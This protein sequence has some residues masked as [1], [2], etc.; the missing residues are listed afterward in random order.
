LPPPAARSLGARLRTWLTRLVFLA[1]GIVATLVVGA[2][3]DA[4]R[5]HPELKPWHRLVPSAESTAADLTDTTTLAEYQRREDAVFDQVHRQI[6]QALADD[7]RT[8]ANRYNPQGIASPSRL[9]RDYNRTFELEPPTL[10]G[11]ALLVHGLSDSPYSMRALAER[12]AGAGYYTLALRMQGHGSVP[13]GLT[14]AT[15][16]DWS[17]A[18]RLGA[19]HV[20]ERIGAGRPFV[21]VGYSNG[22]A[23][24]VRYALDANENPALPR[25]DRLILLCP[26]MGVTPFARL[27]SLISALSPI[28]YFDRAAWLDVLPEYNPFK[29]N[30]F[31]TNAGRQTY[32]LTREVAAQI[33]RQHANG[34]L[35]RLAPILT[36]QS[37]VDATV[38]T[39][40]VVRTLYSALP[41]NGSELVLFDLNRTA[42]LDPFIRPSD[43]ALLRTLFD[44]HAARDYTLTVIRNVTDDTREVAEW[45]IAAGTTAIETRPLGLQ[46]P[47]D[48]FS[49]SHIAMPFPPDDPVYGA[50]TTRSPSG[51]IRLGLLTPRGERS[52]LTVPIDTLMRVSYNPFFSYLADRAVAWT[53][54]PATH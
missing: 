1:V 10:K 50:E 3:W 41:R 14:R 8:A 16:T 48:V 5:R 9:P 51:P 12:L 6:E 29:F 40:A 19:R 13:G 42:N 25:P 28:P 44:R 30:S 38:S 15:W 7:D 53:S 36:F 37:L 17:A 45:R 4:R 47:I 27:A 2:G 43:S 21:M 35:S 20:R 11:G 54:V 18:V 34:S 26:M 39:E 32:E 23:L 33:E 46:W 52:V 49:L 22:G 24:S 31:P